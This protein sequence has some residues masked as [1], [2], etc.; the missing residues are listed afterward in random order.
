[1]KTL[2]SFI[3]LI[4][5]SAFLV[6]GWQGISFV[7][8]PA[9]S[10]KTALD[11]E[12]KAGESFTAIAKR[13]EAKGLVKNATYLKIF[14]KLRGVTGDIRV[15][16]YELSD[17]MTPTEI[18]KILSS[19]KSKLR[20]FTV[21]EGQNIFEIA[22]ILAEKGYGTTEENLANFKDPALIHELLGQKLPSLEGYLFP[23]TYNVTKYT[24]PKEIAKIMVERFKAVWDELPYESLKMSRHEI[25]TLASIVE[26]ETG[27]PEERPR[28]ASVFHNRL[29]RA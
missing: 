22:Q 13:L 6:L 28:I 1:M 15:G 14:S 17:G 21:P 11:F 24:T 12:V 10:G 23:E 29:R 20:S 5:L 3:V 18:L 2:V 19:G 27:A 25:V 7:T 26:K 16:E 4:V 8:I 9:G